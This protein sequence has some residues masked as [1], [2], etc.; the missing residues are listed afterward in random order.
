MQDK[1]FWLK[2]KEI[3]VIDGLTQLPVQCFVSLCMRPSKVKRLG[4]LYILSQ[5][6]SCLENNLCLPGVDEGTVYRR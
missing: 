4:T 2:K 3:R 5:W 1:I 6:K